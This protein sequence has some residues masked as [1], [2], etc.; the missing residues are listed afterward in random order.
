[1]TRKCT[2]HDT[3]IGKRLR[4][5]RLV[6][7]L[8]QSDLADAIGVRFQQVQKYETGMNRISASKLFLAAR[9]LH[10]D[11]S[12]FSI[13][14]DGESILDDS[15]SLRAAHLVSKMSTAMKDSALRVLSAMIDGV[16]A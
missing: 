13:N 11:I 3:I 9:V 2:E 5:A 14:A 15:A 16:A 7:G 4:Y 10:V 6:R 12:H 8:S 1:M